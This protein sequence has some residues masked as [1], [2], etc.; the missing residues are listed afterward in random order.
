M[1]QVKNYFTI[2]N[3][4]LIQSQN[5]KYHKRRPFIASKRMAVNSIEDLK[6]QLLLKSGQ[7]RHDVNRGHCEK[8]NTK[9]LCTNTSNQ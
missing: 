6:N 9:I 2:E 1:M 7:T 8:I 4:E 5:H 3:E